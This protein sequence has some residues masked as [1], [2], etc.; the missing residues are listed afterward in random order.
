MSIDPKKLRQVIVFQN[1]T[2]DDLQIIAQRSIE[3]SLEEGEFFFFQGDPATYAYILVSG[4]AKLTQTGPAGQQVNLRTISEWEMFGALGAVRDN[5]SYP[6]TAQ[7]MEQCTALAI[8][9]ETLQEMMATRS[10]LSFDLMRLMTNYIQEMQQRY[11][12]LATEKVERRIARVLLRLATQLG[13]KTAGG[14]ELAFTRQDLAEM[15][16][17]TLYTVSRVLSDWERQGLV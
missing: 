4:R 15:S 8:K 17:T 16:G 11:R 13:I 3:R 12:E 2:D 10:Y 9:S 5:A 14:I 6:A 1:A 7:A